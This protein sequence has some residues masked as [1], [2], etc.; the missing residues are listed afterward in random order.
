MGLF[1]SV[2]DWATERTALGHLL[3]LDILVGK[4][5]IGV[6]IY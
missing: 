5:G 1:T 2:I 6:A 4:L 3:F